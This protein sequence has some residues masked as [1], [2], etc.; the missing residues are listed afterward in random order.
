MVDLLADHGFNMLMIG[1]SDGIAYRKHPE[2]KRRYSRPMSALTELADHAH[3]RGL[4]VVPKL[5]F[6]KSEINR[7]DW[8]IREP[9]EVWHKKWDDEAYWSYGLDCIDEIIQACRPQ[10]F[11][12]IGMDE[13]HERSYTQYVAAIKTLRSALKARKLRTICWSDLALTYPT[14]EIYQE[15]CRAAEAQTPKDIVRLLWDYS[16]IP[17]KVMRKTIALGFEQW[18]APG[19]QRL[20]QTMAFRKSLIACGGTGLVMTH[21]K[22][23]DQAHEAELSGR[24]RTFAP[25]YQTK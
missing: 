19:H 2:L 9:G 17:T 5:N 24:I 13:D 21:W 15:K 18:A 6:S 7:H 20:E 10:R 25:A 16:H 23:C 12:H 3:Q 22:N 14:G 8:W 11:F 4:E 1:V